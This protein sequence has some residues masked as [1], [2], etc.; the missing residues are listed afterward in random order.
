MVWYESQPPIDKVTIDEVT[1]IDKV[2]NIIHNE[3]SSSAK[4]LD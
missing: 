3:H 2:V 4:H 1:P